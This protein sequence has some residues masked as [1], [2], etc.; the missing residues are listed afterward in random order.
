MSKVRIKKAVA[1][2]TLSEPHATH[3]KALMDF[4][5]GNEFEIPL[6]AAAIVPED[7][8]DWI[9]GMETLGGCAPRLRCGSACCARVAGAQKTWGFPAA[10]RCVMVRVVRRDPPLSMAGRDLPQHAG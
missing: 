9:E 1:D 7:A 4:G 2:Y 6:P 3:W 10:R 5:W 8:L